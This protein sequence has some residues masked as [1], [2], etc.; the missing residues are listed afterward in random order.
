M[1]EPAGTKRRQGLRRPR[2]FLAA[3][4][5]HPR[6]VAGAIIGGADVTLTRV[7]IAAVLEALLLGVLIACARL[8]GR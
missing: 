6:T 4:G 5:G 2:G 1:P 7:V 3:G 8:I